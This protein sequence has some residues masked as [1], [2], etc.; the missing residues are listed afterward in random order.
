MSHTDRPTIRVTTVRDLLALIPFLL[1]FQPEDSLVVIVLGR[2]GIAFTARIALAGPG[3]V[4]PAL[5]AVWATIAEKVAALRDGSV[6]LIG[7]GTADRVQAAVDTG[8]VVLRRAGIPISEVL[9]VADGHYWHLDRPNMVDGV[10]FDPTASPVAAAAVYAGLVAVP[11]RDAVAAALAPIA[12]A[13]R[14]RMSTATADACAFLL[15]LLDAARPDTGNSDT[16]HSKTGSS[17]DLDEDPDSVLDTPLGLA[18]QRGARIYLT[19]AQDS[20][21]TGRPV[22]DDTAAVLT[23]LLVLPSLRDY[24]ARLTNT[25]PWQQQMWTDLIRRAEPAFTAGPAALLALCALRCGDGALADIA[26]RR[27]LDAD[28]DDRLAQLL[29]CAVAAGIG[30]DTVAALLAA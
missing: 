22:D 18:L 28:P 30:P 8:T 10:A 29:A 24:A 11:S 26:V 12:G 4:S 23:V 7:Y 5:H 19:R 21:R 13:A 2:D 14:E 1:R 16:D 25:E 3:P 9:R 17:G 6:V 27:A 20:Y 15:E